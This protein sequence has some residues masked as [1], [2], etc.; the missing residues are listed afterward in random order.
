[1]DHAFARRLG[2][3]AATG[4]ALATFTSPAQAAGTSS[5]PVDA[6]K[7]WLLGSLQSDLL[8]SSFGANYGGSADASLSLAKIGDTAD[9]KAVATAIAS[10]I[11]DYITGDAFGDANSTYAGAVAKAAVTLQT[12]GISTADVGS[13]HVD[14]ISKLEGQVQASGR[15]QDTSSYGD[16]EN[17]LGQSYAV[18][19]LTTAGSSD[20][21]DV[22]EFLLSQQC[23][24]GW[25][26]QSF[27]NDGASTPT[28]TD[29]SCA[30]DATSTPSVDAT[31]TAVLALQP[32]AASNSTAATAVAHAVSWLLSVQA[33]DGSWT[34]GSSAGVANT[35]S[36]GL[37][38]QA[39]AAVDGTTA[40]VRHAATFVREQQLANVG[41]CTPFATASVGAIGHTSSDWTTGQGKAGAQSDDFWLPTAQALPILAYVPATAKLTLTGPTGFVSQGSRHTY[42]VSGDAGG[43]P[44]C[45][46]GGHAAVLKRIGLSGTTSLSI[47]ERIGTD[48]RKIV[49]TDG[50]HSAS[51]V[52]K[53]LGTKTF[54]VRVAHSSIKRHQTDKVTITGLA[55]HEKVSIR[56]RGKTVKRATAT[57]KGTYVYTLHVGGK[58]GKGGVGVTGQFANRGG[59]SHITVTR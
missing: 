16:Y 24:A 37:A 44:V 38:G 31:A 13:S 11:D 49:V 20:A 47:I 10:H 12:S 19:A 58:L 32:L 56:W 22:T 9:A 46:T 6:A 53:V 45:V 1:M 3:L 33:A 59:A 28:G 43:A 30:D 23:S 26:R 40:P 18:R 29:K 39:I 25:F 27:D 4:V 42:R 36:T 48:D 57:S 55:A 50:T 21:S 52:T 54:K 41:S 51:T 14:L 7:T 15:I 8:P 34:D 2:L 35:N 17:V 5:T